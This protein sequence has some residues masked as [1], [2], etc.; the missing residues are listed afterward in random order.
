MITF[1]SENVSSFFTFSFVYL[2]ILFFTFLFFS[3]FNFPRRILEFKTHPRSAA[4]V[5]LLAVCRGLDVHLL[6]VCRGLDVHLL[7]VCR[8]L[9]VHLLAVCRG[10]VSTFWQFVVGLCPPF[11]SLPWACV[12]L[13]AVCRGL[14]VHRNWSSCPRHERTPGTSLPCCS[15]EGFDSNDDVIFYALSHVH[16]L[17]HMCMKCKPMF[18][19][20]IRWDDSLCFNQSSNI[21]D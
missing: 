6:A 1:S 11:G 19:S 18:V 17:S 5:H 10:L 9:D 12:H 20:H 2:L 14:D 7:A 13:L 4:R 15:Y 3:F 16:M 8:G 21:K